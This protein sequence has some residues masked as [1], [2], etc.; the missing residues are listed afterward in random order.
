MTSA[1]MDWTDGEGV[2]RIIELEFGGNLQSDATLL[3]AEGVIAAYSSSQIPEPVF[4]YYQIA[5]KGGVIRIIQSFG[6]S[7]EIRR[8]VIASVNKLVAKQKLNVSIGKAYPL[9]EIANAHVDV[10]TEKIIGNVVL[11]I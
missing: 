9:E 3:R 7:D 1:I 10:E 4:P 8:D 5:S 2:D 11:E 6:F